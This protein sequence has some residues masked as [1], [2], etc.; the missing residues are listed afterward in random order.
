MNFTPINQNGLYDGFALITK[1]EKKVTQK[2][3]DYLDLTLSDKSGEISAKYWDYNEQTQGQ[4]PAETLVK[5]RGTISQYNGADQ[6]RVE[7][8]RRV[9]DSDGVRMSDFVRSADYDP[10]FMY[11]ELMKCVQAFTDNDLQTL[12]QTL[13]EQH[14]EQLLIWP[15]AFRLHHALR[16]GL[17]MHTLSIV[18]LCQGVCKVYPFVNR[19]LLLS[20]AILHDIAKLQ[21]FTVGETGIASGYS[22]EGN[23]IGH[24]V[25]GARMVDET[26]KHLGVSAEKSMLL[27]HMILSHHGEPDFG[28][29]VR[30]LFLEAELLSELDL[31]DARI[32][33]IREATSALQP[34]AFTNRM[35]ALEDRKMFNHGYTDF[36]KPVHLEE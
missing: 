10:A 15:A 16:S 21:E 27:Q 12:V 8:M 18:R 4:F 19:D 36:S 25:M 34:G 32:Y 26:A 30:P 7:R 23:L 11:D 28:A 9:T 20:G 3:K 31:M 1:S 14:R 29:A 33:Q 5:V 35:W 6:F 17:L 24:L 22:A 2:G 13:L